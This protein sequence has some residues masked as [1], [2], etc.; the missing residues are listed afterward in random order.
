MEASMEHSSEVIQMGTELGVYKTCV[1]ARSTSKEILK[2]AQDGGIVTQ[3]FAYALDEGIID[4]AI[5]AGPGEEPWRPAPYVALTSDE[6]MASRGT[7]YNLSPNVAL[8]KEV[9]RITALTRSVS[10]HTL[11]DACGVARASCILQ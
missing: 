9:T 8:I 5:V 4:G 10:W 11:P 1:S 7:K 6:L 3:L 2:K